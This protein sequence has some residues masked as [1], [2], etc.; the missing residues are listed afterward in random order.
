MAFDPKSYQFSTVTIQ[1]LFSVYFAFV[2]LPLTAGRLGE[3]GDKLHTI[4]VITDG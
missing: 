4:R 1:I 3:V 2:L